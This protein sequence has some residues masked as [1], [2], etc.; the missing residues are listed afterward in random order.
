V[1]KSVLTSN[2][3]LT[4]SVLIFFSRGLHFVLSR[5]LR[6][7]LIFVHGRFIYSRLTPKL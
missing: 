4:V 2:F 6:I 3:R 1:I 7:G 5:D